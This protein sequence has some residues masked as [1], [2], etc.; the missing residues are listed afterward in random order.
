MEEYI[1]KDYHCIGSGAT[2]IDTIFDYQMMYEKKINVKKAMN[3]AFK[4]DVFSSGPI[5]KLYFK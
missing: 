5:Q 3:I 4:K 2:Y 1:L